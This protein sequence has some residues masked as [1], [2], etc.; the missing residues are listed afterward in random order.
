MDRSLALDEVGALEPARKGWIQSPPFDLAFFI[1][2]PLAGFGL[3]LAGLQYAVALPAIQYGGSYMIGVPHYLASF[4]F[5]LGDENRAYA[6]RHWPWYFAGPAAICA[7]V[8]ALYLLS[9]AFIVH[10]VLFVWNIYHV[11]AQ[12]SGLLSLYRNLSG[13]RQAERVWAQRTILFS[14]AAMAFWYL[15]RFPPLWNILV[16][17]HAALPDLVR[18]GCLAAALGCGAL[19]AR[20]IR[21]RGFQLSASEAACL[22]TGLL[23]F[24]PYLWLADSQFAT[25]AMLVG[26][27]IQYLAIVWLLNRRKYRPPGGSRGQRWLA[28]MSES[29]GVVVFFMAITGLAFYAFDKGSRMLD[30]YVVFMVAFNTLA[31]THFYLDG[32]IWAFKNPFIRQTVGPFLTLPEHRLR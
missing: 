3:G 5:Y 21:R 9:A 24:T 30:L 17:F 23:L 18:F 12:S 6:W 15:D 29:G 4:A 28:R 20:E 16:G 32:L 13:G 14:N 19:Y 26:H 31:L 7:S 25:L 2:S 10:A 1:L 27:F 8:V 22:A 11:A